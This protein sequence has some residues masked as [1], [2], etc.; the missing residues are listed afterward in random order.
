[1]R[2]LILNGSPRGDKG[3]TGNTPPLTREAYLTASAKYEA[4][5]R[6]KLNSTPS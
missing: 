1:M 3:V 5:C 2:V 6:K 4:W